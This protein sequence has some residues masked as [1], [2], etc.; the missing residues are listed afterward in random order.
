M[1][2]D[3]PVVGDTYAENCAAL[4]APGKPCAG[5]KKC[6]CDSTTGV[7]TSKELGA[8]EHFGDFNF[9][10]RRA[11]VEWVCL[12]ILIVM[13]IG[14]IYSHLLIIN[15]ITCALGALGGVACLVLWGYIKKDI[16]TVTGSETDHGEG[17]I[18]LI[19]AFSTAFAGCLFCGMDLLCHRDIERF[20]LFNDGMVIVLCDGFFLLLV[21]EAPIGFHACF[22]LKPVCV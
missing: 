18:F 13:V 9:K 19:V 4:E 11:N 22:G 8:Y 21:H 16:D 7:V 3:A 2:G 20:G 17:Y 5:A 10:A 1:Q 14:D 15:V 12:G 6:T